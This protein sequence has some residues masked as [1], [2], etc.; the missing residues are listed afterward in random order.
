M[1]LAAVKGLHLA[2]SIYRTVRPQAFAKN[3]S[4][5]APLFSEEVDAT[6]LRT[7]IKGNRRFEQLIPGASAAY[8]AQREAIENY[9]RSK[10]I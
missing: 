6:F 5:E 4:S 2:T 8:K 10:C 3:V 9:A 7:A 1:R